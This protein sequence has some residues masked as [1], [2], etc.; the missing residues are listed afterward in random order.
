MATERFGMT[1]SPPTSAEART[2]RSTTKQYVKVPMTSPMTR[3][4]K[5]SRNKVCTTRGEN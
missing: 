3:L 5:G 4:L 2:D 1:A